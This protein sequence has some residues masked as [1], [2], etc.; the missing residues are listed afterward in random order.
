MN[1]SRDSEQL[2]KVAATLETVKIIEND[3]AVVNYR[4]SPILHTVHMVVENYYVAS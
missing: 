2:E 4:S 3:F 1:R